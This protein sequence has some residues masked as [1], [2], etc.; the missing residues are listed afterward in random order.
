M[1]NQVRDPRET[2][3]G[4]ETPAHEA[5]NPLEETVGGTTRQV[6][7]G[8]LIE[9][10]DVDSG[11]ESDE[12]LLGQ[13]EFDM[14]VQ[15]NP[16]EFLQEI[17]QLIRQQ[18]GI[19][20]SHADALEQIAHWT[21]Q[22]THWKNKVS[23]RDQV[24]AAMAVDGALAGGAGRWNAPLANRPKL[25][26]IA[27]PPFFFNKPAEDKLGFDE[28]LDQVRSKLGNDEEMYPSETRKIAY[29]AGLLRGTAYSM[30]APRLNRSKPNAYYTV[31]QLY[32]HMVSIWSNPNKAQD[33]RAAFRA[34]MMT[35]DQTFQDFYAEF[36]RLV[37]E[38]Q[39]ERQDLK[40]ELN[41]KLWWK[42]QESVRVYYNDADC[43]LHAFASKCAAHDRQIKEQL[44]KIPA[45]KEKAT[46]R[47]STTFVKEAHQTPAPKEESESVKTAPA[48]PRLGLTCYNCNKTGHIARVCPEP[49]TERHKRYLAFVSNERKLAKEEKKA[50]SGDSEK[51][52]S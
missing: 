8:T 41:N 13:E 1:V 51:E 43:N 38:G 28:W 7:R 17:R 23:Q 47:T 5:M 10:A 37:A 52:D 50:E 18:R 27:D 34:L 6:R 35:K 14:M 24:I 40:D 46:V 31:E 2:I 39:I 30:I 29:V 20:A 33:A 36:S 11:N 44:K 32:E 48:N 45:L 4:A 22:A 3:A 12:Q 42:L 19:N 25:A 26:K 15:R 16:Q 49:K 9:R 21:E